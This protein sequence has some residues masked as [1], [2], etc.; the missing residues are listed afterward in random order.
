VEYL[1]PKPSD[2]SVT[3]FADWSKQLQPG[4]LITTFTLTVT[5]GTVTISDDPEP[6]LNFG[7]FIRFVVEGGANGEIAVLTN[8]VHTVG[9]QVMTRTIQLAVLDTAEPVTPS[10][11]TKRQILSLT[12]RMMGLAD[13]EFNVSP[14]EWAT[15]L[16]AMDAQ[17][18]TWRTGNLDLNYNAPTVIG[19]SDL[20]DPSGL[21]D[22][23]VLPVVAPWPSWWPPPSARRSA[24]KRG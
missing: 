23:A 17:M 3:Y 10:T 12:Y 20:D 16:F 8:T 6:P 24:Q 5:S 13:Y 1:V 2:A 21:P 4:D 18:A 22:D 11:N 15:A 14:E 9:G 7:E 19:E